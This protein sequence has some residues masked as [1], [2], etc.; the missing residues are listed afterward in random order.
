MRYD[1]SSAR[2][3]VYTFKEGLLSAVAHDLRIEVTRF[4][5]EVGEGP[6][7][8][9]RFDAASLRVACAVQA[10]VDAP[11]ALSPRDRAEIDR[12]IAHDV[13]EARRYPEIRF[14]SNAVESVADGH[15]IRGTLELHGGARPLELVAQRR[16]DREC[17][18]VTLHQPDF[19]IRPYRALLGTLR[20]RPDV[21]VLIELPAPPA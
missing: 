7:I 8:D 10:G 9:A 14:R 3:E 6:T 11:A 19:G 17:V 20:I 2:C 21:R 12:N 15:R 16:G 13:L 5:V 1:P 4:T 18:E